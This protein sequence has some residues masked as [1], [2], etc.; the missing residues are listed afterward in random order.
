[1]SGKRLRHEDP[2]SNQGMETAK[3]AVYFGALALIVENVTN[4]L[5]E[6]HA[7]HLVEQMDEY[8]LLNGMVAI[9]YLV[10]GGL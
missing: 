6:D 4:F 10:F 5:D 1:M 2:R 9:H 7:H 3:L 8:L